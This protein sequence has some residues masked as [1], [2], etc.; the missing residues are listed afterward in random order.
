LTTQREGIDS[1]F[2]G[3]GAAQQ[4]LERRQIERN[5]ARAAVSGGALRTNRGLTGAGVA[6]T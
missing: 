5:S 1:T 2:F 4:A 3:D 6:K